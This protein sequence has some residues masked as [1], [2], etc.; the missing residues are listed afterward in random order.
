MMRALTRFVENQ[1]FSPNLLGMF[2]N[3]FFIAR[4]GLTKNIKQLSSEISGKILDV[5]CGTKPYKDFFNFIEYI[6]LEFDTGIDNEKKS[7]D[8]YYDGKIFPFQTESFDSVICNQVLEHI[9]EPEDFLKETF[10]VLKPKGKLLLTVP[11]VWDEHEQPFD[12]AR[13]S[14]FGLKHLLNRAGFRI[15]IHKRSVNNISVIFQLLSGYFYKISFKNKFLKWV[16]MFLIIFPSNLIG[17][18]LG[19]LLP[20]N[21]DLFL[22][23]IILAEKI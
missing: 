18:I 7:A 8:Y 15:I 23:N 9:F 16:V 11:F 10:R 2:F 19:K 5:G 13:Y 14:S 1:N 21:N 3:P 4:R 6:G 17:I 12:F 20:A 22:D